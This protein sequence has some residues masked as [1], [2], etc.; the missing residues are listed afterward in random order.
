RKDLVVQRDVELGV[1]ITWDREIAVHLSET[2]LPKQLSIACCG[3]QV[4]AVPLWGSLATGI[5]AGEKTRQDCYPG[6]A[7]MRVRIADEIAGREAVFDSYVKYSSGPQESGCRLERRLL[8]PLRIALAAC[9]G[10][11]QNAVHHD[12]I[13]AAVREWEIPQRGLNDSNITN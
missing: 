8:Q 11:F 1:I 13:E 12:Q 4:V 2:R 10:P 3:V 9:S 6:H 5:E 7:R